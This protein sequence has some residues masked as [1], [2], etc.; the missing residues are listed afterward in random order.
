VSG[1]RLAGEAFANAY[2]EE[3]VRLSFREGEPSSYSAEVTARRAGLWEL[4]LAMDN[5][6]EH[7][8]AIVR[9]DF[10][11]AGAE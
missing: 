9:C 2:S 5:G 4:R 1:A 8:T 6:A 3:I 10:L 7:A 11:P